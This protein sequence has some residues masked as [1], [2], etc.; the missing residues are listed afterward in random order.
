MAYL[1]FLYEFLQLIPAN[2][3]QRYIS[4]EHLNGCMAT[5][6]G[7]LGKVYRVQLEMDRLG[8]LFIGGWSQFMAIHGITETDSLQLRFEGNMVFTVKVFGPNGCQREFKHMEIRVQKS[9]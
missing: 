1:C 8:L 9:K 2:F 5:I 7:P 3:V 6:L 4:K